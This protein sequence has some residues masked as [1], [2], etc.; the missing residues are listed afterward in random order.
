MTVI[1]NQIKWRFWF[2][3]KAMFAGFVILRLLNGPNLLANGQMVLDLKWTMMI[4]C[5]ALTTPVSVRHN[6]LLFPVVYWT[7][8]RDFLSSGLVV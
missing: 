7:W 3:L 4:I 5:S 1:P 2:V 6:R 8:P